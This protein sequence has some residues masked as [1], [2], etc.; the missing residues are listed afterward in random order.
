V[1]LQRTPLRVEQ[2]D[3]IFQA[4]ILYNVVVIYQWRRG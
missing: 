3:V 1:L 4:G 2:I